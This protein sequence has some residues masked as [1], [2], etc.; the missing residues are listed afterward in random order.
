MSSH[1][2]ATRH[3]SRPSAPAH[4]P[5]PPGVPP[6]PQA[7]DPRRA[8]PAP[9]PATP[10]EADPGSD[11]TPP[12]STPPRPD[13]GGTTGPAP[14]S[15]PDPTTPEGEGPVDPRQSWFSGF[16][17]QAGDA[18]GGSAGEWAAGKV[19]GSADGDGAGE[20]GAPEAGEAVGA[21]AGEA[22]GGAVAGPY[23]VGGGIGTAGPY[24]VGGSPTSG[25]LLPSGA[26]YGW[27]RAQPPAPMDPLAEARHAPRDGLGGMLDEA[28][29]YALEKSGLM[30]M[31][32]KVTGDLAG[33]NAAAE[34]W[35]AQAKAVEYVAE[36]LRSG[37][38]ALPGQWEGEA[39]DAFG[40][41]MGEVLE[42]LDGTAEEMRTTA[43]IL[44]KCAQECAMA[45]GMV[46][47]II[48]EAIEVLIA[49]LAAE[50]VIAVF[51]AGI[52]LIA[53]ALITEGE[54]AVYV[55]RVARVSNELATK[56][57]KLLMELKKLGQAVKAVRS[58]E[59]ARTAVNAFKEV[60]LAAQGIR[61]FEEGGDGLLK[62][63]GDALRGGGLDGLKDAATRAAVKKADGYVTGKAEDAFNSA[64]GLGETQR[65]DD[66]SAGGLARA[67]GAGAW[68][69]AKESLTG[70]TDKAAVRD[71]LLHGVLGVETEPAPYR[72]D[73]SRI[74][75]AFG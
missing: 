48:S 39:S 22:L 10:R 2:S 60:K 64:L 40:R 16:A 35:Q 17:R 51:T 19:L 33:L 58:V 44:N 21:P 20:G 68:G 27:T 47:E 29:V 28:V 15:D 25:A 32:E 23:P 49:S 54:I 66:L 73:E 50:A 38:R 26:A 6:Q 31:L 53:D 63:G 42:A 70:D 43:A 7:H 18:A 74:Q 72:V 12:G 59:T 24:P 37:A 56:L 8:Q 34:E 67:A 71:A 61:E 1:P 9:Q 41:R 14:D 55:A 65:A 4:Q 62:A 30:G 3:P 75:Q 52:G 46:V 57:E 69:A 13:P 11:A 45:E 5:D 36:G